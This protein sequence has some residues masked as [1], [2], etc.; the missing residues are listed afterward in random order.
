MFLALCLIFIAGYLA[1]I[2]ERQLGIDKTASALMIGGLSWLICFLNVESIV[3]DQAVS[4]RAIDSEPLVTLVGVKREFLR[5]ELFERLLADARTLLYFLGAISIVGIVDSKDG[6][7]VI[8]DRIRTR[9]RV[10]ILWIIAWIT[11]FISA[12]LDNLTTTVVMIS[13]LHKVIRYPEP[14]KYFSGM[15]VIAANAGG[16]WSTTGDLMTRMLWI[17]DRVGP[18]ELAVRVFPASAACLFVALIPVSFILRREQAAELIGFSAEIPPQPLKPRAVIFLAL[19]MIGLMLIPVFRSTLSLPLMVGLSLVL[20]TI[21]VVSDLVDRFSRS[22]SE[23]TS[24]VHMALQRVDISA[25]FFFL[26][27]LLGIGA[28]GASGLFLSLASMIER[29]AP[30]DVVKPILLGSLAMVV[31]SITVVA[32]GIE[33]YA[34]PKNDTFWTLL[35]Y[36]ASAAGSCQLI[37]SAAGLAAISLDRISFLWYLRHI[38]PWA[39]LGFI[40]GCIVYL[41]QAKLSGLIPAG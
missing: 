31:E 7:S 16:A 20:G 23:S 8:S 25:V 11:F 21:W 28:L 5:G 12:I 19:G 38:T 18:M 34:L 35:A 4:A 6:F 15:V 14:R 3:P 40:S 26:G 37:G 10:K 27:I 29:I 36:C 41:I 30:F 17:H 39:L 1:I 24:G 32:A 2:F 9:N 22:T 33:M 13:M